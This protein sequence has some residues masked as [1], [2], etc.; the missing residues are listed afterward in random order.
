MICVVA[1]EPKQLEFSK[2]DLTIRS[3]VQKISP[4]KY[5]RYLAEF[6]VVLC[7]FYIFWEILQI[8]L[9]VCDVT[10]EPKKLEF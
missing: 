8:F 7:Y 9:E 10:N 2:S 4:I 1:N 6:L 3:L 5:L